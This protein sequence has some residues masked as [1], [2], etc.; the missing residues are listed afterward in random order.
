MVVL[1]VHRDKEAVAVFFPLFLTFR[2]LHVALVVLLVDH[3]GALG[4][5]HIL[6]GLLQINHTTANDVVA[7]EEVAII[8]LQ[9]QAI[10]LARVLLSE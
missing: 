8:G 10:V 1:R 3:K 6:K 5:R 7:L 2:L 9:I 4:K